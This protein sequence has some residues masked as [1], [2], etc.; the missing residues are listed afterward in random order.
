MQLNRGKLGKTITNTIDHEITTTEAILSRARCF[1]GPSS[2][3]HLKP[4]KA[5]RRRPGTQAQRGK[6]SAEGMGVALTPTTT[7]NVASR[8]LQP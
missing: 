8:R 4:G 7:S 3:K 5:T 6:G 2:A 1:F